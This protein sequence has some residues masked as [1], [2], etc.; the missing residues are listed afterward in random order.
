MTCLLG[1]G[2]VLRVDKIPLHN[3]RLQGRQVFF[4]AASKKLSGARMGP[5]KML[6]G[7]HDNFFAG[8]RLLSFLVSIIMSN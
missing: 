5:Q 2:S 6:V 8:Y 1:Y 4:E 7:A 3:P